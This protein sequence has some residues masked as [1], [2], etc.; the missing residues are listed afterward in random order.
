[1]NNIDEMEEIIMKLSPAERA[2]LLQKIIQHMGESF[3]NIESD[4]G[5]C[6]GEPRIISYV[7]ARC[8][9]PE[10]EVDSAILRVD[11]YPKP[12][13][14]VADIN[15]FFELVRAGFSASRKQIANSLA[16]GLGVSKAEV[17]SLLEEAHIVPRRRAETLS[18]DEWAQVWQV[19]TQVNERA[20]S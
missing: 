18:L 6:G 11:L 9:Y 3:P 19:F 12:A 5:I 20:H 2:Q 13:V 14:A 1:M 7:P 17:L 16:Q 4:P 15:G 8:F 10:P